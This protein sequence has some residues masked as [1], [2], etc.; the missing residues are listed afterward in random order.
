MASP[1]ESALELVCEI[2]VWDKFVDAL[3]YLFGPSHSLTVFQQ[4]IQSR[5]LS[6]FVSYNRKELGGSGRQGQQICCRR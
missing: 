3:L 5:E 6:A 1:G 4:T 2:T